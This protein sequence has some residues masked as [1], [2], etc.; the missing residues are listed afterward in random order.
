VLR[1]ITD[2]QS[3]E[4]LIYVSG[5][6]LVQLSRI[7]RILCQNHADSVGVVQKLFQK[8]YDVTCQFVDGA[9]AR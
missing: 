3:Q 7:A 5:F 6:Q 1:K 8:H 4:G 9:V 2:I